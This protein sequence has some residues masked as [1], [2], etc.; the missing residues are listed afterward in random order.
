MGM[1]VVYIVKIGSYAIPEVLVNWA[2]QA[3]EHVLQLQAWR[4]EVAI[5]ITPGAYQNEYQMLTYSAYC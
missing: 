4:M 2:C 1:C 5:F 3:N